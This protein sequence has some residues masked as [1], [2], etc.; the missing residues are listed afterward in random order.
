MELSER[1]HSRMVNLTFGDAVVALNGGKRV[2][3]EGWN[4]KGM[5]V[6]RQVPTIVPLDAIQGMTSLPDSVKSEF[7]N[8][9]TCIKYSNQLAIVDLYNNVK[10]WAPSAS[11]ALANDWMILD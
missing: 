5:F 6:F 10:G 1:V 9:S 11:D 4:G 3:R 2:A 7:A 8:R